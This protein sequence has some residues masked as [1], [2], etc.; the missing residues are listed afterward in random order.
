MVI[1]K[2]KDY[3]FSA[4]RNN[5]LIIPGRRTDRPGQK[6]S[7]NFIFLAARSAWELKFSQSLKRTG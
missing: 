2:Q 1:M 4:F 7:L 5:A 6:L 3:K